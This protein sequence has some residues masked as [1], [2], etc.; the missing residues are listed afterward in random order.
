M[1]DIP[2]NTPPLENDSVRWCR[3]VR[4]IRAGNDAALEE[5]YGVMRAGVRFHLWRQLGSCDLDDMVHDVFLI[6]R[7]A[8]FNGEVREPERLM[9]FVATVVRRVIAGR[10]EVLVRCRNRMCDVTD[11]LLDGHP[12]PEMSMAEHEQQ[13]VAERVLGGLQPMEREILTR[14]YMQDQSAGQI[15]LELHLTPTQFR[16]NK[17][18]AKAR[19]G[20]MGRAMLKKA[21]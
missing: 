21:G 9:G 6:V 17:G 5:L 8:I 13:Q 11:S 10:I 12:D 15:C 19:F 4:E 16:V 7:A 14:F 2:S 1:L 18:R 20:E 3:V